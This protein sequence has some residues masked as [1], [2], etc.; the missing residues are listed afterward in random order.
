MWYVYF[1]YS[2]KSGLTYVG[3]SQNPKD[4]LKQHNLRKS[5]FTSGHLPWDLFYKEESGNSA[6]EARIKEI[7]YKTSGREFVKLKLKEYLENTI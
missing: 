3:I 1:L 2:S 7:Y 4:R 6:T 5:K